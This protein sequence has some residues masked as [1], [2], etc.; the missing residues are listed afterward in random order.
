MVNFVK[1]LHT[2][3]R[4]RELTFF[5]PQRRRQTGPG[6]TEKGRSRSGGA[7]TGE[8]AEKKRSLANFVSAGKSIFF[9]RETALKGRSRKRRKGREAQGE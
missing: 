8:I 6:R 4:A 1:G 3:F 7:S 9:P 5:Y 2:G